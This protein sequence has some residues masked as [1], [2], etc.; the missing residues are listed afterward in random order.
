MCV[1]VY[2]TK[3]VNN[4]NNDQRQYQQCKKSAQYYNRANYT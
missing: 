1:Y 3:K 4:D 2:I